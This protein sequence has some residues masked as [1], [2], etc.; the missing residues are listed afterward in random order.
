VSD[1]PL[2]KKLGLKEGSRF[3]LVGAP[4]GFA[5]PDLPAGVHIFERATEPLDVTLFFTSREK[6]LRGRFPLLEPWLAPAGALWI[7]WPKRSSGRETDLSFEVVQAIG[8]EHGL[9]DNKICSID[10]TWTAVRFVRRLADR[11]PPEGMTTR[12]HATP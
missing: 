10:E 8:L 5:I 2:W 6:T 4:D 1:T 7:A 11:E 3:S 9:V 12:E